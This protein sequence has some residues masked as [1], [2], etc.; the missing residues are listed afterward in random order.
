MWWIFFYPVICIRYKKKFKLDDI[1][2]EARVD[3]EM[4]VNSEKSK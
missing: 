3:Q 2:S 1:T 4:A